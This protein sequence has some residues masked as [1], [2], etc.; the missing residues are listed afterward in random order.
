M[1]LKN[2]NN[3]HFGT[4]GELIAKKLLQKNGYK[5][6]K[7]NFRCR[8]GEIDIIAKKNKILFFVEVKTRKSFKFGYPQEA[9]NLRKRNKIKNLGELYLKQNNLKNIKMKI[10]VVALI[11]KDNKINYSKIIPVET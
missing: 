1:P 2:K 11:L 6:I 4:K 8:F 5:I 10:L 9:V 3:L 7:T